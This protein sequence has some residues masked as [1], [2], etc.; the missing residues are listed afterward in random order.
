MKKLLTIA[1]C[2]TA[3]AAFAEDVVIGTVGVT[4]ISTT[5]K[6]TIVVTSYNELDGSGAMAVSNIVKTANLP[7]G[8]KLYVLA[9][10]NAYEGYTLTGATAPKYWA[11]DYNYTVNSSGDIGA[12]TV[13]SSTSEGSLNVGTGF[14]I[15]LPDAASYSADIVVYGKPPATTNVAGTAAGTYLVGNPT[16]T[17]KA[18]TVTGAAKGD[19]LLVFSGSSKFP[20]TYTSN[21]KTGAEAAWRHDGAPTS[22]PSIPAGTGF[23]YI[24]KGTA[25]VIEW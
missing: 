4:K 21:G 20:A 14:W 7:T 8:T 10:G 17:G 19:K 22:L 2:A 6:N 3:V 11:R 9:G 25:A 13:S 18:P 15:S 24:A 23:W 12:G 16:Q 5:A 1:I